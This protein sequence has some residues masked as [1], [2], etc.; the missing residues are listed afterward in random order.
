MFVKNVKFFKIHQPSLIVNM[1]RK[2]R[3]VDLHEIDSKM[4]VIVLEGSLKY[5]GQLFNVGQLLSRE[6]IKVS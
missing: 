3:L 6:P 2:L 5:Q 4:M 1:A